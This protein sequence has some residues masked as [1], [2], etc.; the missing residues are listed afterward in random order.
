MAQTKLLLDTHI[1]L[2]Y[3]LGDERL[4]ANHRRL[5]ETDDS[6]LYLSPVSVWEAHLLIEKGRLPLTDSPADWISTALALLPVREAPLT[7]RS[8]ILARQLDLA[9]QDPAD[10]FIAATA[11]EQKLILLTEDRH[12]LDCPALNTPS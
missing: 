1:W 9:H 11:V 7:L 10:R 4:S 3:L 2:W 6:I 5:I 12:L 8:A